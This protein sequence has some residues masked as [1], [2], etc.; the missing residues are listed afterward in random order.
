M[1]A[2]GVRLNLVLRLTIIM[3]VGD[4]CACGRGDASAKPSY[5]CIEGATQHDFGTL[6]F[7]EQLITLHH[8]F[9]LTNVSGKV[10]QLESVST[11][12]GR[13]SAFA[14]RSQVPP[15]GTVEIDTEMRLDKPGRL[16]ARVWLQFRDVGAQTLEITAMA[17][18]THDTFATRRSIA[19]RKDV[20]SELLLVATNLD[21]DNAPPDPKV[22]APAPVSAV[23]GGWML[24]HPQ[25]AASGRPARWHG[26]LT[27]AS[28]TDEL[29][30][31]S[32]LHLRFSESNAA[33]VDLTG[34]PWD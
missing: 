9:V 30:S 16:V 10:L 13:T 26:Y 6:V 7:N 31:R 32:K 4:L 25:D 17:A 8:S 15:N 11:S 3:L 19:L 33:A 29:P 1:I 12:C 22:E 5:R 28:T 2:H 24:V 14:S 21:T 18:R 20:P 27:I 23:F 34:W